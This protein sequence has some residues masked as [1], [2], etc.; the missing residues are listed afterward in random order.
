VILTHNHY[1]LALGHRPA[2]TFTISD[3][4]G[5][6][7]RWRA[8]DAQLI[9][10]NAGTALIWMPEKL[11]LPAAALASSADLADLKA[12]HWLSVS[13]WDETRSRLAR[14]DFQIVQIK[15]GIVRLA[16]PD[17]IIRPGDSGGGAYFNGKLVGNVWSINLDSARRPLGSFNVALLPAQVRSYVR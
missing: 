5:R 10:I 13:Y 9:V 3:Q 7:W 1:G 6:T 17:R 8:V 2:D 4:T 14:H 12:G 16:D 15:D 11:S